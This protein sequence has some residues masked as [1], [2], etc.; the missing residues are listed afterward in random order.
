[1]LGRGAACEPDFPWL[2]RWHTCRSPTIREIARSRTTSCCQD[3]S[4]TRSVRSGAAGLFHDGGSPRC[5]RSVGSTRD[6]AGSTARGIRNPDP[7]ESA[8]AM[9]AG[10]LRNRRTLA[11]SR[12][13]LSHRAGGDRIGNRSLLKRC[14]PRSG[15]EA[16][17][18]AGRTSISVLT[19]VLAQADIAL[20]LD[21]A[22]SISYAPPSCR[23]ASS[24]P[25]G[26][27]LTSG[28]RWEIPA[29]VFSGIS[30]WRPS[31]PTISSMK[32][33]W[34]KFATHWGI[35]CEST[36]LQLLVGKHACGGDWRGILPSFRQTEY[37]KR[38]MTEV[39]GGEQRRS[40]ERWMAKALSFL[41]LEGRSS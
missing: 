30:I 1:M 5:T 26:R 38:R 28:C 22:P 4:G 24:L 7:C 41:R 34:L 33:P 23:P 17:S 2:R 12:A 11:H 14:K 8:Q 29:S 9:E 10:T 20:T 31:R 35:C 18:L 25:P 36:P 32:F 39:P 3:C 37:W 16:F 21:T 15:E 6:F 19:A 27:L 40:G 13:W